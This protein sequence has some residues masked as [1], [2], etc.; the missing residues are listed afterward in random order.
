MGSLRIRWSAPRPDIRIMQ[1][2]HPSAIKAH[3]DA[4]RRPRFWFQQGEAGAGFAKSTARPHGQF[5]DV[6]INCRST[7]R[8]IAMPPMTAPTQS[9][10]CLD[11]LQSN[12]K[13]STYTLY[14]PK[15]HIS[16]SEVIATASTPVG[17]NADIRPSVKLLLHNK[18]AS[19]RAVTSRSSPGEF[20]KSTK[21]AAH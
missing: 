19:G 4:D 11:H 9:R 5:A 13:H 2:P 18:S 20:S 16:R 7:V 12:G 8:A 6:W 21:S 15:T 1:S 10:R 3:G 14:P 17:L